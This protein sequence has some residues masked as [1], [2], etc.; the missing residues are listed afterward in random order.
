VPARFGVAAALR[1]AKVLHTGTVV[2]LALLGLW[3]GL[4]VV[5][6]IGVAVAALLL[7]YEHSLLRPTDL[8]KLDVAFFNVNGYI[9]VTLL[10]ATAGDLFVRWVLVV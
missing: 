3:M 5:Y 10:A 9:A 4:G 1:W 2:A 7:A 6:G 8:S